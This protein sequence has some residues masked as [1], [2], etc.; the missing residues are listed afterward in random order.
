[1]FLL[2]PEAVLRCLWNDR[3]CVWNGYLLLPPRPGPGLDPKLTQPTPLPLYWGLA[4][5]SLWLSF[6]PKG[7]QEGHEGGAGRCDWL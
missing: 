5:G 4:S 3:V 7:P 6:F 2:Q 1:M